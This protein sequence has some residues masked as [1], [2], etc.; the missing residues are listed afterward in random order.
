MRQ[1]LLRTLLT[2][3]ASN[4]KKTFFFHFF[5]SRKKKM[6]YVF[7]IET[8]L[9]ENR[10]P[11]ALVKLL[12]NEFYFYFTQRNVKSINQSV[13]LIRSLKNGNH[14]VLWGSRSYSLCDASGA[15]LFDVET[16]HYIEDI[17]P[18]ENGEVVMKCR[19]DDHREFHV[20]DENLKLL[21]TSTPFYEYFFEMVPFQNHFLFTLDR[22]S[23]VMIDP[24]DFKLTTVMTVSEEEERIDEKHVHGKYLCIVTRK[25]FKVYEF[26]NDRFQLQCDAPQGTFFH[27]FCQEALWHYMD[28]KLCKYNPLTHTMDHVM[29]LTTDILR[30]SGM[31]N[32]Q[33][34]LA[35]AWG[36][37][38]LCVL[39]D[40]RVCLWVLFQGMYLFDFKYQKLRYVADTFDDGAYIHVMQHTGDILFTEPD[41]SEH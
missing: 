16:E 36:R 1:V 31:D 20:Y 7:Q 30:I 18:L 9:R 5:I 15:S 38:Q 41:A 14:I 22:T 11:E 2:Q 6:Q 34:E 33:I 39:P 29:T 35:L 26:I 27:V 21:R 10:V 32:Q 40:S 37:G 24:R 13:D 3:D 8:S 25:I 12:A 4:E 28:G 19:I 23:V 17:V